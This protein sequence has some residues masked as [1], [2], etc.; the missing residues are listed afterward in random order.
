MDVFGINVPEKA[1]TNYDLIKCVT[2]QSIPHFRC[3]FMRDTLPSVPRKVECGNVNINTSAEKGSHWVCYY[4]N[5]TL[6]IYFDSFGQIT[7]L[8]VQN[9][10]KRCKYN[11]KK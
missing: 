3:V 6:C 11:S 9:Y 4:K 8:E 2:W 10:L 5:G 1:L 7:P